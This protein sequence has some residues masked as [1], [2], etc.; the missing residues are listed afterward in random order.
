MF[1]V[2]VE[3]LEDFDHRTINSVPFSLYWRKIAVPGCA[4]LWSGKFLEPV[5]GLPDN[6]PEYFAQKY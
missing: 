4:P 5:P 3:T 2:A 6:W 1:G